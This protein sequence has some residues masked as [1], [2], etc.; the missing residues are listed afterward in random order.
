MTEKTT[1]IL[2]QVSLTLS[3]TSF[4]SLTVWQVTSGFWSAEG[5]SLSWLEIA[6]LPLWNPWSN[7]LRLKC[8]ANILCYCLFS[9]PFFI[10]SLTSVKGVSAT[11][12][13][14]S[15]NQG[16]VEIFK[17]SRTEFQ[18]IADTFKTLY[19]FHYSVLTVLSTASFIS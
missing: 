11:L 16:G 15:E 6:S 1:T 8:Q 19:Y 9:S 17:R 5:L 10:H 12:I 4:Y 18:L 7:V 13:T 2:S 3:D 14:I